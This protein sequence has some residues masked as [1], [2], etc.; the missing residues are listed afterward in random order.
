[1]CKL[2]SVINKSFE[3]RREE[4]EDQLSGDSKIIIADS[5]DMESKLNSK[6][7]LIV[8]CPH[9]LKEKQ[10]F[11]PS[12]LRA[13]HGT[14][15]SSCRYTLGLVT[16]KSGDSDASAV[17]RRTAKLSPIEKARM[18]RKKH[19]V[20]S[21]ILTFAWRGDIA[22]KIDWTRRDVVEVVAA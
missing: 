20:R 13:K 3:S 6:T 7:S 21:Q 9:C 19:T 17:A 1:M 22:S 11:L 16:R 10:M 15:C 4:I 14:Y 8:A 12:L 18:W 5:S 2:N